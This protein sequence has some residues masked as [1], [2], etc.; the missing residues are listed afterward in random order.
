MA[1]KQRIRELWLQMGGIYGSRWVGQYGDAG[2]AQQVAMRMWWLG[3][4]RYS[5]AAVDR[6]VMRCI[7]WRG[8][9]PT[10]PEFIGLCGVVHPD[11]GERAIDQALHLVAQGKGESTCP[12]TRELLRRVPG[13]LRRTGETAALRRRLRVEV[14]EA[15]ASLNAPE[16][17][18][19][20]EQAELFPALEGGDE[21][22]RTDTG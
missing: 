10:L 16:L 2:T 7:D 1:H 17:L 5:D 3:L 22:G 18:P 11:E 20:G 21:N 4:S 8:W 14:G 13:W 15:I 12:L 9:P 19:L 6:A